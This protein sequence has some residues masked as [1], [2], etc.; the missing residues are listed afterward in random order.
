METSSCF[1]NSDVSKPFN[2]IK[3]V[4]KRGTKE[5]K[6]KKR[7]RKG[8]GSKGKGEKRDKNRRTALE[9]GDNWP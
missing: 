2:L 3:R 6:K 9:G 5:R 8:D 4:V 1:T 7:E